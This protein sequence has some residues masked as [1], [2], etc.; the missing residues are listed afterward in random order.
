MKRCLTYM[1]FQLQGYLNKLVRY[2][3][4]ISEV[5]NSS[6]GIVEM[7]FVVV[8]VVT[9]TVIVVINARVDRVLVGL[10]NGIIVLIFAC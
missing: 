9:I 4:S 7:I 8:V 10:Y 6:G 2:H 1:H 3:Q 5:S